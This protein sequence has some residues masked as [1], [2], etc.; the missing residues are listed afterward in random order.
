[1]N[2]EHYTL[3][4]ADG[5]AMRIVE[6]DITEEAVD[7]IV[8]AANEMLVHG[9]GVAGAIAAKGGPRVTEESRRWVEERG[10]VPVGS[11]AITSGGDL[12]ARYVIHAVGPIWDG[13]TK[14]EE[15][16]LSSAVSSALS[17]AD[18]HGLC[19]IAMPAISTGIF[20]Y[21]KHL[22]IPAI[23]R[24]IVRYLDEHPG[25]SLQDVRICDRSVAA[26]V[27]FVDEAKRLEGEDGG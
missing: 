6:G 2:T 17:L 7:A 19:S 15:G 16:L 27:L 18:E 5:R 14:G 3:R 11:A 20:G 22:A 8:N 21:P 1:M 25:S 9:G 4:R 12:K 13:G 23:L 24:T 10:H 26:V